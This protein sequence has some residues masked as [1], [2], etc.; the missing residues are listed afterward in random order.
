MAT[1]RKRES[2]E[3]CEIGLNTS[4]ATFRFSRDLQNADN[5]VPAKW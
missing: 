5:P 4:R 3:V 1:S 2:N